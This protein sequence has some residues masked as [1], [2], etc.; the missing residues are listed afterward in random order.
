MTGRRRKLTVPRGKRKWID[1]ERVRE[2]DICERK[3]EE[4]IEE[5]RRR[6]RREKKMKEKKRAETEKGRERRKRKILG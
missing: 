4:E 1:V 2:T 5:R 3:T 6:K